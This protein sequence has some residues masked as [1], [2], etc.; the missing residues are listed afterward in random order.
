MRKARNLSQGHGPRI[1]N[2]KWISPWLLCS[3]FILL[4]EGLLQAWHY[5][6]HWECT[7][8]QKSKA[9][10]SHG[11]A[12]ESGSPLV[13]ATS[14]GFERDCAATSKLMERAMVDSGGLRRGD[15]M[16]QGQYLL[17]IF[18]PCPGSWLSSMGKLMS[19]RG[20]ESGSSWST[21][22]L[23]GGRT[24]G[25]GREGVQQQH[26]QQQLLPLVFHSQ[27]LFSTLTVEREVPV[28]AHFKRSSN[29]A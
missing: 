1:P 28:L 11:A 29:P 10:R 12:R 15:G 5:S 22:V 26:E 8:E 2:G 4:S 9:P 6:R 17:H 13:A 25:L 27:N 3:L 20:R 18:Q 7:C 14:P 16:G 21:R 19:W 23:E 24:G